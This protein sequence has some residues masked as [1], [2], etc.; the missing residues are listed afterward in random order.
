[1]S[2]RRLRVSQM[3]SVV[4]PGRTRSASR[5]GAAVTFAKRMC[6]CF[7]GARGAHL[8]DDE[9]ARAGLIIVGGPRKQH[10]VRRSSTWFA[11][12]VSQRYRE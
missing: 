1:M 2:R 9:I 3:Q 10:V 12:S 11:A 4:W 8:R 7:V 6:D 5:S